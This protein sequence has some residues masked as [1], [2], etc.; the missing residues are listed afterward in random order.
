MYTKF[1]KISFKKFAFNYDYLIN[2]KFMQYFFKP[3]VNYR[4]LNSF[5]KKIKKESNR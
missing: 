4:N 2:S 3:F 1:F 5:M